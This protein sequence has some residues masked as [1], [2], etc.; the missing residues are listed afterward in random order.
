MRGNKSW[1]LVPTAALIL[2]VFAFSDA[3]AVL[4]LKHYRLSKTVPEAKT[5]TEGYV[6][7]LRDGIV[8]FDAY[9]YKYEKD[10]EKFCINDANLNSEKTIAILDLEIA[11]PINGRPYPDDIPIVLILIKAFE[12]FA[13]CK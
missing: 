11:D 8:M 6:N 2:G 4:D 12:R 9:R 13:P 3:Q 10:K 5:V 7:G 1:S